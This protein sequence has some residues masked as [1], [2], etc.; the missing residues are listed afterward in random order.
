MPNATKN[1]KKPIFALRF[2]N[3][4]DI[5]SLREYKKTVQNI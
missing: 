2:L 1:Q 4:N 3:V 5:P